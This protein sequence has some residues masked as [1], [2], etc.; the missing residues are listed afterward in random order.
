MIAYHEYVGS[1]SEFE[2]TKVV[3][4][5]LGPHKAM[6]MHNHRLLTVGEEV[7]E[8]FGLMYRLD[9]CCRA[10]NLALATGQKNSRGFHPK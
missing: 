2:D 4:E 1:A 9:K 10:Q 7:S 3:V 8:A 5:D 6:I